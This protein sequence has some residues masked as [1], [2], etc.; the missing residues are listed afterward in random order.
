LQLKS[1][2]AFDAARAFFDLSES[3]GIPIL[4]RV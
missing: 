2:G 3:V 4:S 1:D